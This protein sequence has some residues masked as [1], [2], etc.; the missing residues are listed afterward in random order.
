MQEECNSPWNFFVRQSH[1]RGRSFIVVGKHKKEIVLCKR[2]VRKFTMRVI[3]RQC[4]ALRVIIVKPL[5]YQLSL[6]FWYI[7]SKF[8]YI[9][10]ISLVVVYAGRTQSTILILQADIFR[11]IILLWFGSMNDKLVTECHKCF[12]CNWKV[13]INISFQSRQ[14]RCNWYY[15]YVASTLHS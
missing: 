4:L 2:N 13:C 5:N 15:I 7:F 9:G 14:I 11:H 3:I 6:D 10:Y 1:V 8:T 12:I